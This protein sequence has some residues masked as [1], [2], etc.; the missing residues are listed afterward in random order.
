[1]KKS[2]KISKKYEINIFQDDKKIVKKYRL[3][4]QVIYK[5][6]IGKNRK[7][8]IKLQSN[9]DEIYSFNYAILVFLFNNS[10]F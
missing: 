1:M 6:N 7:A 10:D 5:I 3:Y 2:C 4:A 8:I 9:N